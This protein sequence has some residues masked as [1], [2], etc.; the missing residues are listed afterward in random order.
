MILTFK[1]RSYFIIN[2]YGR[3]S[4]F[5]TQLLKTNDISSFVFGKSVLFNFYGLLCIVLYLPYMV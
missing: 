2:L 5:A 1:L 4:F 3:L